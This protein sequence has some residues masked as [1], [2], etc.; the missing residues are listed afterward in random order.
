MFEFRL[1][2]YRT[3]FGVEKCGHRQHHVTLG[4][5]AFPHFYSYH[6]QETAGKAWLISN[7]YQIIAA[8]SLQCLSRYQGPGI[9]LKRAITKRADRSISSKNERQAPSLVVQ[10][11][12][13]PRL[14]YPQ[15]KV[16]SRPARPNIG[17]FLGWK[18][19]DSF[20]GL[21]R[22]DRLSVI[23]FIH[24]PICWKWLNQILLSM[25]SIRSICF[26]ALDARP[27]GS[28]IADQTEHR[29]RVRF[30][31]SEYRT[32]IPPELS[33]NCGFILTCSSEYRTGFE[34]G[35]CW[36]CQQNPTHV[37]ALLSQFLPHINSIKT[38]LYLIITII[39]NVIFNFHHI[40][41]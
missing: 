40:L 21:H 39:F 13:T 25:L 14:S 31:L 11:S 23:D 4:S 15:T 36:Q 41:H 34:L 3:G 19:A 27:D 9:Q 26:P 6:K 32:H 33:T 22:A 35:K 8:A 17:Q 7:Y 38:S 1:T 2:E 30:Q 10:I 5:V 28:W 29:H 12:D 24:C 20:N 18:S 37:S 16:A